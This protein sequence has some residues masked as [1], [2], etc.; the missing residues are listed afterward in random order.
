MLFFLSFIKWFYYSSGVS[1]KSPVSFR[2]WVAGLLDRYVARK[3]C[4]T[5][6]TVIWKQRTQIHPHVQDNVPWSQ[7][8]FAKR[9][10]KPLVTVVLNLTSMELTAVKFVTWVITLLTNHWGVITIPPIRNE[11]QILTLLESY[12]CGTI[13][14]LTAVTRR[15]LFQPRNRKENPLEPRL[16]T[17]NCI[18]WKLVWVS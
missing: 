5:N 1:Q 3:L 8:F 9:R 12:W 17:M 6:A 14:Q 13:S 16:K 11:G 4:I 7:R 2:E 10:R 15:F 18:K